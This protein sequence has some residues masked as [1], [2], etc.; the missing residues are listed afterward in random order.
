MSVHQKALGLS[1]LN[2]RLSRFFRFVVKSLDKSIIFLCMKNCYHSIM[3]GCQYHNDYINL[4]L[5][6]KGIE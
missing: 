4:I 6:I 5:F 2:S 1:G 3:D